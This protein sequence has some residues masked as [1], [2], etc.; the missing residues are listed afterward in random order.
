MTFTKGD[1]YAERNDKRVSFP[2]RG[3]LYVM[4]MHR[5]RGG[6]AT[7]AGVQVA[8]FSSDDSAAGGGQPTL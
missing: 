4:T 1:G 6:G 3:G 5:A 8:A 2:R 7:P